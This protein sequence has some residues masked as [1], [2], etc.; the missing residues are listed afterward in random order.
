MREQ[1]EQLVLG[2]LYGLAIGLRKV[3]WRVRRPLLVGV[4]ALVA[5]RAP[6]GD[7]VLLVRHRS[8]RRPWAIPGGGVRRYERL[9]EAAR[10]E[11]WEETGM[12]VR[13][14]GLLGLYD[15]FEGG[16]SNYI[17]VFYCAPL[18][19]LRPRRSFE[20]AEARYFPLDALPEGLDPASR[21]RIA[22]YCAGERGASK[23]W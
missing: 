9:E 11:A 2:P 23:P 8:G 3:L 18:E 6:G 16:M 20:I 15:N 12:S 1:L 14:E 13:I 7:E 5:R 17:A 21:R 4:R 22:E 19:E 10:R